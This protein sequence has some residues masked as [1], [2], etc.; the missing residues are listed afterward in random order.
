MRTDAPR[1]W[2]LAGLATLALAAAPVFAAAVTTPPSGG[3]RAWLGVVTQ[4]LTP[5]LREGLDYRGQG[6]LV[7]RVVPD[8]PADHAGLEKGDVITQFDA[9]A[10]ASPEAL[11]EIVGRGHAGQA[12]SMRIVRDGK[13]QSLS[14]KLAARPAD[15]G[16]GEGMEM[17]GPGRHEIR[18]DDLDLGELG[19]LGQGMPGVWHW[20]GRGRLGVRIESLNA[21][22]GSYF[23]VPGGKGVLIVEVMKDTPA[24]KA[25]LKAGDVITKVGERAVTGA[26]DLMKALGTDQDKVALGIVRKGG[27][28]TIDVE[29]EKQQ[30]VIRI[31]R[32]EGT[33]GYGDD[34]PAPGG[35]GSSREIDELRRQIDDL[36]RRLDRLQHD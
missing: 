35:P 8:S 12:V 17:G 25:G 34:R 2:A 23:S 36:R 29:L 13:V 5:E 14:A 4:A 6:V 7:N 21:D 32:G 19:E 24:E 22:L 10:I 27:S 28:R 31:R 1:R 33:M 30:H 26:G 20:M 9:R 18:I 3:E 11:A 15:D 16:M